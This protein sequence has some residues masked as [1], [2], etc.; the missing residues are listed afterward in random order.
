MP[1]SAANEDSHDN[2]DDDYNVDDDSVCRKRKKP[3]KFG[4]QMI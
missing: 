1:V 4:G 3:G 2:D